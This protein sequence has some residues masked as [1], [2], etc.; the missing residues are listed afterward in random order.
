L[1]VKAHYS[2]HL[3]SLSPFNP[4]SSDFGGDLFIYCLSG[5]K[6]IAPLRLCVGCSAYRKI[7]RTKYEEESPSGVERFLHVGAKI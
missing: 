1:P 7:L 6:C 4:P 3:Q 2:A 5:V